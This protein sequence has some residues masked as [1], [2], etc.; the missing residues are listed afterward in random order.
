MQITKSHVVAGTVLWLGLSVGAAFAAD[1]AP[2]LPSTS[3]VAGDVCPQDVTAIKAAL[4]ASA[5]DA[6]LQN[7][8]GM[9]LQQK[10]K[11]KDAAKAYKRAVKLDP[12]YAAAWNNLGTLNHAQRNYKA[13]VKNYDKSIA[14]NPQLALAH[15]NRGAAC[16]ARGD[17]SQAFASFNQAYQLNPAVFDQASSVSVR[18]SNENM[19]TQYFYYAKLHAGAG[20]L[21]TAF[22]YLQKA[23]ELGFSDMARVRRD[24]D[25]KGVVADSRF[26][27]LAR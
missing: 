20:R 3:A 18:V 14:A 2:A 10:G 12:Q 21:D 26:A 19:A 11:L 25:F 13:A 6:K 1:E 15:K 16:L 7:R 5:D 23:R 17:V 22:Q 9:C 8:M 24:P 27:P 4:A